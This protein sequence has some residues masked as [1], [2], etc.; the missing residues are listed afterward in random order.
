MRF[1]GIIPDNGKVFGFH[2]THGVHNTNGRTFVGTE[3][4]IQARVGRQHRFSDLSRLQ[5]IA[6]TILNAYD[7]DVWIFACHLVQE[8]IAAVNTCPACLVVCNNGNFALA[9]KEFGHF[10]SSQRGSRDV[11]CCRCG[12]WNVT[13]D[14]TV[15]RDDW[16]ASFGGLTQQ[17]NRGLAV[18]RGKA[19]C[20]RF[21]GQSSGQHVDLAINHS[22]V[23]RTFKC[24]AH[25]KFFSGLIRTSF[26]SLPELVLEAF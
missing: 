13:V 1:A 17:R 24:D 21:V 5:L 20:S 19:D 23:V 8:T 15:K 14:A 10:V 22:L 25:T 11:I 4:S 16:D 7:F 3:H 26:D 12:L 9:T 18:E 6:R 2:F